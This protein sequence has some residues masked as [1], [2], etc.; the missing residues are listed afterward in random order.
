[1]FPYWYTDTADA[2]LSLDGWT[3]IYEI[4]NGDMTEGNHDYY[5][6]NNG[7]LASVHYP[8]GEITTIPPK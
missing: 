8:S 1:M 4:P 3:C 5:V 6:H 7:T 2:I